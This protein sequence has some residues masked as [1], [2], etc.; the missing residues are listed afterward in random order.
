[1]TPSDNPKVQWENQLKEL[2]AQGQE[3]D[4]AHL[5]QQA[6]LHWKLMKYSQKQ[7][8]FLNWDS[9]WQQILSL[10]SLLP[11]DPR[12][13]T[14]IGWQLYYRS[15]AHLQ[16]NPQ[17]TERVWDWLLAA[18]HF[19]YDRS[20]QPNPVHLLL[21]IALKAKASCDAFLEF[22]EWWGLENLEGEDFIGWKPSD[23]SRAL[24]PLAEQTYL[25]VGKCLEKSLASSERV[26]AFLSQLQQLK[27]AQPDYH[28]LHYTEARLLLR[29]KA[30]EQA[31]EALKLFIRQKSREYWAW[32][33]LG[34]SYRPYSPEKARACFCYALSL[35][36]PPAFLVK[37]KEGLARLLMD[38]G[39]YPEAKALIQEVLETRNRQG[40]PLKGRHLE[41]QED[42][43]Y[44]ET[45]A[46]SD[47]EAFYQK[48][49]ETA[50]KL[51]WPDLSRR[52]AVVSQLKGKWAFFISGKGEKDQGKFKPGRSSLR[53]GSGIV[54]LGIPLSQGFRVMEWQPLEKA[55]QD[56]SKAYRGRLNHSPGQNFGFVEKEIFVPSYLIRQLPQPYPSQVAGQAVISFDKKKNRWGWRAISIAPDS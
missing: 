28:F 37:V 8:A 6:W 34:E 40:W 53:A 47:L 17:D 42:R 7:E 16:Q 22:I 14:A 30:Y 55:P 38:M 2:Q 44:L 49:M 24:M 31:R 27:A 18:R 25:A 21:R 45:K 35:N 39:A 56:L 50:L 19:S 54:L 52:R 5:L 4:E 46:A 1:M 32:S 3:S 41:W 29:L 23:S 43:W 12:L 11:P 33:A 51:V 20:K 9:H 13:G 48:E 15:K 10:A 26:Q 36:N